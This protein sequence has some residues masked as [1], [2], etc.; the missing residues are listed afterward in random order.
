[1]SWF[2]N[3]SLRKVFLFLNMHKFIMGPQMEK[4]KLT[5]TSYWLN[6][7]AMN[8]FQYFI[9]IRL[10]SQLRHLGAYIQ[11][12]KIPRRLL[13]TSGNYQE[14][15]H[16]LF[17][18]HNHREQLRLSAS[19]QKSLRTSQSWF[20]GMDFFLLFLLLLLVYNNKILR[21]NQYIFP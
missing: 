13:C 3:P 19:L 4:K 15:L 10:N 16:S 5:R 12:Q 8:T 7:K 18:Q 21:S 11:V 9:M 20:T 2:P 17:V 6:C 14:M 1:M